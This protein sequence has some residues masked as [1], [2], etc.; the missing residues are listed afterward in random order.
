MIA[1]LCAVALLA[2]VGAAGLHG[3]R[4]HRL[5]RREGWR[6]GAQDV[7]EAELDTEGDNVALARRFEQLLATHDGGAR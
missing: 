1:L 2:A 6:E 7:I 3:E 4:R 5:G